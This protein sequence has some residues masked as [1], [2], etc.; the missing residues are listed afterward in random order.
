METL[1]VATDFSES[2]KNAS[3]YAAHL[4]K[5]FSARL[6]LVNAI[7][8]PLGGF[9]SVGPL[10][11]ISVLKATA[12]EAL[13]TVKSELMERIGYDPG[14]TCVAEA[15]SVFDVITA[16]AS[17]YKAELIIMGIVGESNKLKEKF[18]GSS[19]L[20]VARG[21]DLP[22][23]IIPEKAGYQPIKTLSFACDLERIKESTLLY[24]ARYFAGIFNAE[25]EIVTVSE[26]GSD[27][28]QEHSASIGFIN[29]HLKQVKHKNVFIKDDSVD[30]ALEY[31]LKFHATQVLMIHPRKHKLFE[32]FFEGSIT[33]HLI[34]R[35]ETPV[36]II[37]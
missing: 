19:V 5:Y 14:I 17:E 37:H 23:F 13:Q 18:I 35:S 11:M 30:E 6:V 3:Y 12:E 26:N 34:F 25:L 24:S 22:L 4:A 16:A 15:G 7:N 8:L 33:K 1:L 10:E 32:R 29:D 31:Y 2:A 20:N 28:G 36:L 27:T 21:S 9:D